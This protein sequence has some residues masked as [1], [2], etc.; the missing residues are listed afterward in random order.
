MVFLYLTG[1]SQR[2]LF[3]GIKSMSFDMI[4]GVPQRELPWSS[5]V[6]D[7]HFK[8]SGNCTNTLA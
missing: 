7:V 1:R 3:D 4:F 8:A 6:C 2:I 5:S